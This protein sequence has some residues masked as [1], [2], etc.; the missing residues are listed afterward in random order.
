MTGPWR[1]PPGGPCLCALGT[2]CRRRG[3]SVRLIDARMPEL[4]HCLT[5][6]Q[7]VQALTGGPV[8]RIDQAGSYALPSLRGEAFAVRPGTIA[9]RLDGA[10]IASAAVVRDEPAGTVALHLY[11]TDGRTVHRGRLLSAADRLLAGLARPAAVGPP[12]GAPAPVPGPPAGPD[13]DQL[14]RL[15]AVLGGTGPAAPGTSDR[16]RTLDPGVVPAVLEA[17]RAAGLPVGV[18]VFAPAAAQACAGRVLVTDR[19]VGGQVFAA[20]EDASVEIEL[21]GV[22]S[23]RLVRS[24]GAHGPTPAIELDDADGRC[25]AMITQFG[26]VG[27][28]VHAEWERLTAVLP[29]G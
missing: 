15:D 13:G 1:E 11:D 26:A 6:F 5:L 18:A 2:D 4:G 16:H 12:S 24:R 9:L 28:R 25:V 10:R 14:A 22:R 29:G 3:G 20:F 17:V 19:T 21:S 23:C 8:A 27:G 7:H